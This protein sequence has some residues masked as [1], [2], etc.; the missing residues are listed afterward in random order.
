M[1]FHVPN[2]YRIRTG[3]FSSTDA[4]GNC[5]AFWVTNRYRRDLPLRVIASDGKLGMADYGW[6]HVSVSYP[7]RCPTWAEMCLIKDL[8]WDAEDCVVQ[9]HP[10]KADYISNHPFCLHMWRWTGGD[11][12]RPP[13][14][15]VGDK[16]IG[17]LRLHPSL[18]RLGEHQWRK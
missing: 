1:S 8:F 2:Q 5:G 16:D 11:F 7:D 15:M 9:F 18:R 4:I 3:R 10:P 13:G 6:E 12:P 17:T 14:W